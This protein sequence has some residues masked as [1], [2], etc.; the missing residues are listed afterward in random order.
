[1]S[2]IAIPTSAAVETTTDIANPV[3]AAPPL[4]TCVSCGS[5]E[6]RAYCPACGQRTRPE[7]FTVRAI[8]RDV[9]HDALNLDRGILHTA[10]ALFRHPGLV[11]AEYV[12]GRTVRYTGPAKYFLVLAAL[13]TLLYANTGLAEAS[14]AMYGISPSAASGSL[15]ARTVEFVSTWLNLIMA[16]GLPFS[17]LS[18]RLFFHRVGYNYAEHLIFNTYVYAQV[19][20][21]FMAVMVPAYALGMG[22]NGAML[23]YIVLSTAYTAWAGVQFFRVP[24]VSGTLRMI[25]AVVLG[26]VS[27][28]VAAMV[29]TVVVM[30]AYLLATQ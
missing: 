8:V 29:G 10:V 16:L 1:M 26:Y 3:A 18:T 15:Q 11:V 2:E 7:R 20:I 4:T 28:M 6:A 21:L 13:T 17:A 23:L 22:V 5:A 19:C 27:Y 9:V 30:V 14:V 25:A 12:Y 24:A